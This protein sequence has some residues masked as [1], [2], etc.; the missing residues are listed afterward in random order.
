M[1]NIISHEFQVCDSCNHMPCLMTYYSL[2]VIAQMTDM[3]QMIDFIV[4]HFMSNQ[5][6]LTNID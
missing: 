5:G 2:R 6:W 3:S 4:R 1:T